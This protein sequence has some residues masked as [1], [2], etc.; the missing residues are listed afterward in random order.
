MLD[1]VIALLLSPAPPSGVAGQIFLG[2]VCPVERLDSPCPDRPYQATLVIRLTNGRDV[3]RVRA[4]TSGRFQF[5]LKP[6][7][8]VLHPLSERVMPR[9]IDQTVTVKPNSYTTVRVEYDSGI[10]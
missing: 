8:Y 1:L 6:G 5:A 4:D 3:A 9:G 2:P 10:R 7:T